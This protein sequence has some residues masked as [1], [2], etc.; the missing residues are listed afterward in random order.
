MRRVVITGI[1]AVTP[2]GN[3]IETMWNSL[4]NGKN[5]I[6]YIK[7]FDTEKLKVKV[8]AEVK[9]FDPTKYIEKKELRKTD[10]FCQYAIAAACQAVE[11]SGIIGTIEDEK[12]G[13]YVGSG[14]GG[15]HTFFTQCE[16]MIAEKKISPFF[17]PMMIGNMA[18]GLIAIRFSA[19]GPCLPVV[20]ACATS[21]HAVGEA[22][23]AIKN[24][25]ADAIITGGAEAAI[26]P[27]AIAGFSSCMALSTRNDPNSSSIPFD[28]RRDGFV[29]GEGAGI[30]V[31]EEYEH[32]VARGAKIYAEIAGYG[33]TCD[34][35]HVTA[36][37]PEAA[38]AAR[39][40]EIALKEAG[41]TDDDTLYINA[42]GT[43][44]PAN[45][46]TETAA[47]KRALGEKAYD[48][49]ISSTK[50][51]TGHMLGATGAVEAI[52]AA[53]AVKNGIV[54]P[55]IGLEEPDPECDLNYVPNKAVEVPLTA[56]A[57]TT[58]GFGGHNA[59][60]ALKQITE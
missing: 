45:D 55:T 4:I 27:L 30:L 56:A 1:G 53:L 15:M 9:D 20:T 32:A 50:S 26:T 7:S 5:G 2:V 23:H 54:P 28:K 8:A 16:N 25:Y 38:G 22:F 18:A 37:D 21:T 58:F 52:V 10:L 36:P 19:K 48:T 6:D 47:F 14:T 43:S 33:N 42:H 29:M 35:H 59:C 49:Y 24:G 44:T 17:I 13:V 40:V 11:D 3:D 34:A 12:L 31:L 41:I 39:C 46:K 51:M 57:S 60:I